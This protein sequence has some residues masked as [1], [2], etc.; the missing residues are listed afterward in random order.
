[1]L[2]FF[3][4]ITCLHEYYI[5][6][7][8]YYLLITYYCVYDSFSKFSFV[9]C[10]IILVLD[11]NDKLLVRPYGGDEEGAD[12]DYDD[13]DYDDNNDGGYDDGDGRGDDDGRWR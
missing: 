11:V 10:H 13:D 12:G 6:Y 8:I 1:M 2:L 3:E 7:Y 5:I 4:W 9:L